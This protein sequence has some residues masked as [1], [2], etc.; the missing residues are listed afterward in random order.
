MINGKWNSIQRSHVI[1]FGK[2]D[3]RPIWENT[4]G[5][6]VLEESLKETFE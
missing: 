6:K 1:K 5:N 2:G 4:L 3:K